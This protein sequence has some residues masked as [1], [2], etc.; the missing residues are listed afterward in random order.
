VVFSSDNG[1]VWYRTDIERFN[2]R[3]SGNRKGM[4]GALHEG[5]HR[6]PFLVRWPEKVKAGTTS[7]EL[8]CFTDMMATFAEIV[9]CE[10][11][12][13]AGQDSFSILPYL[14]GESP[15][16]AR[17]HDLVHSH[18]GVFT[19]ALREGDY[20]LIL[21]H[22]IY[23]IKD[24]TISP[25]RIVDTGSNRIPEIFELYNLSDDPSEERNLFSVMPEKAQAM[26][27]S[28]VAN[29]RRGSSH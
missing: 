6:M 26:F 16:G 12:D 19:L 25:D 18:N 10:M 4:K 22:W 17:R 7:D 27:D 20:K 15:Q 23:I 24:R 28:L 11:P 29:I 2:H 21:P 9:G 3:A 8:V 14:L 5:G 1:P 13:D